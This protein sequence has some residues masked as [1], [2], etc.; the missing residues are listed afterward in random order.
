MIKRLLLIAVTLGLGQIFIILSLKSISHSLSEKSFSLFGQAE[1]YFQF[2][3]I[4]IAAG[5]LS[6]AIRKIALSQDW[7]TEYL[8]YQSARFYFSLI[9]LPLFFLL[10]LNRPFAIFF[11]APIIGLSG[12]YA[13]YG[14]GRPVAGAIIA[15][16]RI[17]LPYGITVII[18]Q[19][20]P[21]YYLEAFLIVL[22]ITYF[23]TGLLIARILK[24]QYIV[25]PSFN[26]F[27][28][29]FS[30]LNLGL[31]NI[32]IYIQGLG[33]MILIPLLFPG[34][35]EVIS[36]AFI[37]LK[38]YTIFKGIIRTIHQALVR[39]MIKLEECLTVDKLSMMLAFVFLAS[40]LLFPNT[41]VTLLFGDKFLNATFFF[42]MLA[43]TCVLFAF[44]FSLGTNAILQN[45]DKKLVLICA[46]SAISCI[47]TLL[48]LAMVLSQLNA[49]SIAL[50]TGEA[51]LSFGL[52]F[53]YSGNNVLKQRVLFLFQN[54]LFL[55]VPLLLKNILLSDSVNG[56]IIGLSCYSI[57]LFLLNLKQFNSV[58][59]TKQDY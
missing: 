37:G 53:L 42:Q 57:I 7:K 33:L 14:V 28:L 23:L 45:F 36:I 8:K 50:L 49:I 6:D 16:I 19:W 13:F 47:I 32:S 59:L 39:E 5:I 46:V 3:I 26:N 30:S 38:F 31:V 24:T 44:C 10:F 43:F 2:L 34:N 52:L 40:I 1:S 56:L 41:T 17:I 15:L 4:V 25:K 54:T 58:K 22:F 21:Q 51:V 20:F 29:Y 9:L 55:I 27:R 18:T 48:I 11:I 12:E 35:F